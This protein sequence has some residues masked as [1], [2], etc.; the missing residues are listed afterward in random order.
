M[1]YAMPEGANITKCWIL[2]T[3]EIPTQLSLSF[4]EQRVSP[5]PTTA[6]HPHLLNG[7]YS[8]LAQR[9]GCSIKYPFS[10]CYMPVISCT[11]WVHLQKAESPILLPRSFL[12]M[13]LGML[14]AK[15]SH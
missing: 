10:G 5:Q 4:Q 14:P 12:Q 1:Y 7:Q 11:F 8:L 2:H 3:D 6:L 9:L 13:D 15:T